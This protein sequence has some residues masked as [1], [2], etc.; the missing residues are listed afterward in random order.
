MIKSATSKVLW[1][2]KATVFLFGIAVIVGVTVGLGSAAVAQ[3][4]NQPGQHGIFRLGA[5]NTASGVSSL[6][7]NVAQDAMLL[8]QNSG[9]GPALDLRVK[10]GQAPMKVNSEAKVADLNADK[11]DGLD[12]EQLRGQ[13]GPQGAPGISGHEIVRGPT[14]TSDEPG[15]RVDSEAVCPEGKKVIGGGA[16]VFGPSQVYSSAPVSH[17]DDTWRVTSIGGPSPLAQA[18]AICANVN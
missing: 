1:V 5:T 12:S 14:V 6:V 17:R 16:T 13:Q 18:V 10:Q 8:V 7:G 11:V 4:Q 3:A 2:G 9:G 15:A